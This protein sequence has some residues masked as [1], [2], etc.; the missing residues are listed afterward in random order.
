MPEDATLTHG[1][2]LRALG[3]PVIDIKQARYG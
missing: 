1:T 3:N 2:Q